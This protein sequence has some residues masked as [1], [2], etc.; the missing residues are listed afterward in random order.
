MYMKKITNRNT[1]QT[2]SKLAYA[3]THPLFLGPPSGSCR[4][5]FSPLIVEEIS[6]RLKIMRINF[7][8]QYTQS[9]M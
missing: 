1:Y 4:C 6:L 2:L 8:K 3:L 5:Y 9:A 7:K